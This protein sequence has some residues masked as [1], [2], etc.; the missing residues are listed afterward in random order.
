IPK[1]E[2]KESEGIGVIEAARGTLIHH[3]V[4]D[5]N[6]L[7]K[8]VNLIVA[9]THNHAPISISIKEAAKSLIKGGK[10]D[11]GILNKI[12]VAFRAYDPCFACATHTLPGNLPL[13]VNVY[14]AN[15]KLIKK[16]TNF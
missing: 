10:V 9:T 11:K 7:I 3:Y 6:K 1:N 2:E 4:V 12:E 15:R 16:I 5:E 14:N 13:A 8:K